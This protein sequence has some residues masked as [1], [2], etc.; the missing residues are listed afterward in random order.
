[1]SPTRRTRLRLKICR[2]I[3]NDDGIYHQIHGNGCCVDIRNETATGTAL[4]NAVSSATLSHHQT[5]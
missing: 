1:M 4:R 2:N 5:R 3:R